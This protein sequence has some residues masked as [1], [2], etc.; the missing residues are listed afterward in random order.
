MENVSSY[1]C[2]SNDAD[3]ATFK[4]LM[5]FRVELEI[6]RVPDTPTENIENYLNRKRESVLTDI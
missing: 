2:C 1:I 5:D 6:K 3:V 4:K